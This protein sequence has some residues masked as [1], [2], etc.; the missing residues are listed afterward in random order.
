M[1]LHHLD[2][3][4][5]H[6]GKSW[7]V[8]VSKVGA[9]TLLSSGSESIS[10]LVFSSWAQHGCL[11]CKIQRRKWQNKQAGQQEKA[12]LLS[13]SPVTDGKFPIPAQ[14]LTL[15]PISQTE[16]HDS[17]YIKWRLAKQV[18]NF[19]ALT[20]G[21]A[22]TKGGGNHCGKQLLLPFCPCLDQGQAPHDFLSWAQA[23]L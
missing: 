22:R 1:W 13:L 8:G 15:C 10:S 14:R 19:P 3:S 16:S 5:L 18:S 23:H 12:C 2:V 21:K 7:Q 4:L 9:G 11:S 20:V 17:L 6:K